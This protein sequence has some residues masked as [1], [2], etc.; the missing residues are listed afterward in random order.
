MVDSAVGGKTG[1]N[2]EQGKNLVGAFH[3]P[4]LVFAPLSVLKTLPT[5]ELR[6]GMAEVVKHAILGDTTLWAILQERGRD[7]LAGR[8]VAGI[9]ACVLRSA[10]F[11]AA[12]V[13]G[14][15]RES[16]TRSLLNFGHTVGHAVEAVAGGALRHGECVALGM[17]AEVRH[18][19]SSGRT[20]PQ[21]ATELES[22]LRVLELPLSTPQK[23]DRG[24]MLRAASHDK[25]RVRATIRVPVVHDVGSASCIAVGPDEV[26]EMVNHLDSTVPPGKLIRTVEVLEKP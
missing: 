22:I 17:R 25:K 26:A 21:V 15:E 8:D 9:E 16:G 20:S 13:A 4:D 18:G 14:D 19:I 11:K 1:V 24:A 5:E 10:I 7:M 23:L 12:V 3:Q 6:S 2:T